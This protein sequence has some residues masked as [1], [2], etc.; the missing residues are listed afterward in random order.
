[1]QAKRTGAHSTQSDLTITL[2]GEVLADLG[3]IARAAETS[4]ANLAY[5]YIIDGLAADVVNAMTEDVVADPVGSTGQAN[6]TTGAYH[7][8]SGVMDGLLKELLG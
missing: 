7:P 6:R 3:K 2:P 1:M 4:P 5:T 8:R